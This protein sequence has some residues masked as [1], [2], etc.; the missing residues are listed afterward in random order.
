MAIRLLALGLAAALPAQCLGMA[1]ENGAQR[2]CERPEILPI[3]DEMELA[4]EAIPELFREKAGVWALTADG[5]TEIRRS[6]NGYTCIVNRD[7]AEAIKPTCYDEEGTATILPAVVYFGNAMMRCTPVADI[8]AAIA[9][10][11]ANGGFRPPQRAGIA[12]MMSPRIVNVMTMPDG[13]VMKGT[14]PPHYMIYAPN[15]TNAMLRIPAEAYNEMPW[16]PYIAYTGPAGFMIITIPD[17]Q[18][19]DS[20]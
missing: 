13:E 9:A 12:F 14:A 11:Y 3:A 17:D 6:R 8:R 16:L 19:K 18:R 20:K 10:R 2:T 1:R 5:F 15:V 4:L 7:A